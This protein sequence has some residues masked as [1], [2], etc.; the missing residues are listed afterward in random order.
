MNITPQTGANA[1]SAS[2]VSGS[3]QA[4]AQ[5]TQR[6]GALPAGL[7]KADARLQSQL[8]RASAS[9]SSIGQ[10]KASLVDTQ[11]SARALTSWTPTPSSGEAKKA[12]LAFVSDFNTLLASA[13]SVTA[14]AGEAA[15]V[16]R[17]MGR[18]MTADF[19]KVNNLRQMGFTKAADGSLKLDAAKF[20][21]AFKASP[22]DVQATL[23][24]LGQLVDKTATKELASEGRIAYSLAALK[25]KGAE[26]TQQQNAL[27]RAAQQGVNAAAQTVSSSQMSRGLA[28]Y[29]SGL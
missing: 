2:S 12:L 6:L 19:S 23:S 4:D 18:A 29:Q 15:Q 7:R 21:A 24:K 16:S 25:R 1:S 3:A 17:G 9:I 5:A 13:K 26:L 22:T 27:L 20:E 11:A 28:A 10:F 14:E 8:D